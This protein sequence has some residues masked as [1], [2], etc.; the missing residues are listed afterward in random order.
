M[1]DFFKTLETQGGQAPPQWL[2][3]HPNP[4]NRQ[5]AI[6]K[7]IANWPPENYSSDSAIFAK[8]RQHA[9]GVKAY[10][11]QEIAQ[12]AKSGQWTSFNQ[13][14]GA[15]FNAGGAK[16]LTSGASASAA[17]PAPQAAAVSLQS[18]AP[19][20]RMVMADLGP[21]KINRPENWQVTM[22]QQQG[23]FASIA[24]AA[25]VTS[26]GVGYGVLL[27]GIA[28]PNGQRVSIDEITSRVVQQ[29]QQN[30]G[31]QPMGNAKPITV[32]GIE[33]RAVMLQ[34][35]SPFANANGQPQNEGDLLV[36]VPQR[37]GSVIV[38]LFVAP[39]SDFARFQP[40]YEA[41]LK[42]AQFR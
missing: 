11:A 15:T 17:R 6:Q 24:P 37:D 14:N 16:A 25:G 39:Q 10:T 41:M 23:Q 35:H 22:P 36:T 27:N 34:S 9:M 1:A 42:S 7:E 28:P 21:L 12:G 4:G 20:Q 19:S 8:T 32:G 40:T 33:G 2:S 18:V 26:G 5:L 38:M 3:D 31:L 13:R 29:M 30:N